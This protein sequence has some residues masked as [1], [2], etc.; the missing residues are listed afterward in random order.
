MLGSR[1][2]AGVRGDEPG[3]VG[4][5]GKSSTKLVLRLRDELS[6]RRAWK[7]VSSRNIRVRK[8]AQPADAFFLIFPLF[9]DA[10]PFSAYLPFSVESDLGLVVV[11][12]FK[13]CI[14]SSGGFLPRVSI[15][16]VEEIA[17]IHFLSGRES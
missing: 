14:E 12:G 2:V 16:R 6:P 9:P 11:M 10:L 5:A 7:M 15:N 1:L 4:L 17:K 3:I 8:P 13:E